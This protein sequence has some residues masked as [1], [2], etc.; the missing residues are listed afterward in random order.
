[1]DVHPTKNVSIG[2][3]PYPHVFPTFCSTT[4]FLKKCGCVPI[5]PKKKSKKR[6]TNGAKPQNLMV[7][8]DGPKA[9]KWWYP[10]FETK[11][12]RG[13]LT[14]TSLCPKNTTACPTWFSCDSEHDGE[15][16]P[17]PLPIHGLTTC[18]LR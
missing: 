8:S 11:P 6:T 2:I 16:D 15:H 7:P 9:V 3:D 13:C 18:S 12:I 10:P 5:M 4:S 1:M 17:K 14:H